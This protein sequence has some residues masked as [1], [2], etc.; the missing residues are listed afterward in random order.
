[1]K[2]DID[3]LVVHPKVCFQILDEMCSRNRGGGAFFVPASPCAT[4]SW[5]P[6]DSRTSG[7]DPDAGFTGH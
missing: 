1:M 7:G 6:T 2:D 4:Q 5:R 3:A